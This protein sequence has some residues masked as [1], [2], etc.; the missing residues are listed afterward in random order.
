VTENETRSEQGSGD[1]KRG[2]TRGETP[3]VAAEKV[4]EQDNQNEAEATRNR[5]E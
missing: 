2:E 1:S 5:F 4:R 3:E